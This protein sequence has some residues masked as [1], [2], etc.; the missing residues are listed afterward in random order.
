MRQTRDIPTCGKLTSLQEKSPTQQGPDVGWA[1]DGGP[2]VLRWTWGG[3]TIRVPTPR[4]QPDPASSVRGGA[5]PRPDD[6]KGHVASAWALAAGPWGGATPAAATGSFP[7]GVRA[8]PG[9]PGRSMDVRP[10]RTPFAP[11]KSDES[12][13]TRHGRRRQHQRCICVSPT[14]HVNGGAVRSGRALESQV[15][16]PVGLG[17]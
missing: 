13:A 4:M 12:P 5:G 15:K 14:I 6:R 2:L 3:E 7:D 11:R 17:A 16:A 9:T 8:R 10:T 1:V